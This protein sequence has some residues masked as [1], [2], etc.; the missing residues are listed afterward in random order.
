MLGL[1]GVLVIR[2]IR[3]SSNSGRGSSTAMV[4]SGQNNVNRKL[5]PAHSPRNSVEHTLL[6]RITQILFM[7][8]IA[9]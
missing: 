8:P 5:V 9:L 2:V 1:V 7:T 3:G 4:K 6:N